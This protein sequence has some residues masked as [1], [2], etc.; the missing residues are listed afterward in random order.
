M[1]EMGF[2]REQV[3]RA[4]RASF[5]NPDRAVEY[6][7]TGIPAHL[8]SE[9][10]GAPRPQAPVGTPAPAA[11]AP[12]PAAAAPP[13]PSGAPQNLFQ[14]AQQQQ[15]GAPQPARGPGFDLSGMMNSPQAQQMR[16]MVAANPQLL[17]PMIQ[18]LAEQNPQLA[19]LLRENPEGL[20]QMLM[21]WAQQNEGGEGDI[22]PGAQVIQITEEERAAIERLEGLGF[23][24]QAVIEA[25]FAC[26]KDE[27]LAANYLFEGGFEDD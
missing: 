19:A 25:Y 27:Q 3:M 17:Q 9:A 26:D 20:M 4:L 6:L 15:Q 22:P 14:L 21:Q 16:Q 8:E 10:S 1:M 23:S 13:P 2:E 24:R 11:P 18:Q 7:M 12:Q 5:N